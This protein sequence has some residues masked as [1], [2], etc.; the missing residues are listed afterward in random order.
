[1][2]QTALA[3]WPRRL[4]VAVAVLAVAVQ[5][6]LATWSVVVVNTRTGEVAVGCA[7][8]LNNFNLIP[9]VP[10]IYPGA[11]AG[12]AQSVLD[13]GGARR[14]AMWDGFAAGLTPSEIL[15]NLEPLPGHQQRQYGIVDLFAAPETFTGFQ[16]GQGKH[17]VT[18]IAG[19]YRYAM[20][21][22]LLVGPEPVLAAEQALLATNGDLGQKLMAAMEA[23]AAQGGDGR[24][25]CSPSNPT[26]CGA[27]PPGTWKSAHTGF[28]II[29]RVGDK[30][31]QCNGNAGCANGNYYLKRNSIGTASDPD[32]VLELRTKFDAW[33]AALAGRPDH[34]NSVVSASAQQLVADGVSA[35]DVHVQLV[36]VDGQPLTAGGASATLTNLSGA[37]DA[38]SPGPV[39]DHGDGSYSFR[40][41]A[42][43]SAGTDDWE[44]AFDDG[45]G[46]VRLYP[47]LL[48]PVRAVTPLFSGYDT[49]SASAGAAVPLVANFTAAAAGAR[50][51]VA[52]SAAGTAPGTL[53]DGGLLPLN[54]DYLLGWSVTGANR[55]PFLATK[56]TLDASGRAEAT[57]LPTPR[58]LAPYAGGHLDWSAVVFTGTGALIAPPVGF[59]VLP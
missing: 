17:G 41:T 39:T 37:P 18:G 7:A 10:V 50:Y 2:K 1:M 15:T 34:I 38:T 48:V 16:A 13:Q 40:L 32:P 22:N 58:Q 11:G 36:D 42:G 5:P 23:A 53:F 8:C 26:S 9:E 30:L 21:G 55:A 49:V 3:P 28:L 12:A 54:R 47:R 31:G 52:G 6:A 46:K 19:D 43:T 57:F 20:Q 25:S 29:A 56:G 33:R 51:V 4:G 14:L 45:M 27:P 44:L 24:C 59:D 35:L